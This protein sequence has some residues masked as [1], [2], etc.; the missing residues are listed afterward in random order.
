MCD[1]VYYSVHRRVQR[2][3]SVICTVTEAGSSFTDFSSFLRSRRVGRPSLDQQE[4][5]CFTL[6]A[7]KPK[8]PQ[9]ADWQFPQPIKR[10]HSSEE[11]HYNSSAQSFA[12][13]LIPTQLQGGCWLADIRVYQRARRQTAAKV[14]VVLMKTVWFLDS[15]PTEALPE[16]LCD[17]YSQFNNH[18]HQ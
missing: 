6:T 12:F 5:S 7:L 3:T 2:F 11:I 16:K 1:P 8:P 14:K 15:V 4:V 13:T 10:E 17:Q 9:L 18:M